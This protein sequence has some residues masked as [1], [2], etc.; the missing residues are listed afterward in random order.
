M[1]SIKEARAICAHATLDAEALCSTT[2]KEAKATCDHTVWE[3]KP[4]CSTDNRDAETQGASQADLLHWRHVKT[5]QHL[6]E[7]FIQEEG[8]S[9]IDFLFACQA[10]LQARPV[11]L[12]GM[13]VASY[14]L[15]MGQAPMSHP[16]TLSQGASLIKQ[17][18]ALVA[19]SSPA[20]EHSPR[21]K[22]QHHLPRPSGQ[23]ASWWDHIQDNLR[24]APKLQTARDS[25]FIQGANMEPLRS[26]Q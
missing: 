11:E 9:Q 26:V 15:L 23:H 7:Q 5:I 16:F 2:I 6:E 20:P 17:P 21:A 25:T 3:A 4:I 12:R 14:H 18:S 8:K 19:P 10:A 24:R 1:E 13:L 22:W